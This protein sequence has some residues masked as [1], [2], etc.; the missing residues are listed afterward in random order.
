M[1]EASSELVVSSIRVS[2][3]GAGGGGGVGETCWYL[4]RSYL[5]GSGGMLPQK[6]I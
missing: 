3:G 4:N 2:C 6:N 1:N 5:G